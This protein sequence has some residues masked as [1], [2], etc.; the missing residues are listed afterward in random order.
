MH[1]LKY[2]YITLLF[3]TLLTLSFASNAMEK[4]GKDPRIRTFVYGEND[5]FKIV[6]LYGYQTVIEF[7]EDELIKTISLGDPSPFK[8]NPQKN[9]I[10]LK[11]II[12]GQLTNLTIITN[13]RTYNMEFSSIVEDISEVMYVVRFFYPESVGKSFEIGEVDFDI[14]NTRMNIDDVNVPASM[15]YDKNSS[16]APSSANISSKQILDKIYEQTP[17]NN[18]AQ[19]YSG[20]KLNGSKLNNANY[21]YS[22]KGARE[23][24][25]VEVYDDGIRTYV[26]FKQNLNPK[27]QIVNFDGSL[28]DVSFESTG[29]SSYII[30][31]VSAK[32]MVN[33]RGKKICI[34][35]DQLI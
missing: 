29:N 25:P 21:N 32:I 3:I 28:S 2:K 22:L 20:N 23:I 19:S 6:T 30:N 12:D 5:V 1:R 15:S 16:S 33:A 9:K 31:G 13:K 27:F 26:R 17:F 14:S 18:N 35:N 11:A 7:E 34:Y 10:F 24:S 4:V 8:I